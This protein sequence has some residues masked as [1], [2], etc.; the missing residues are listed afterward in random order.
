[1]LAFPARDH[2]T[3]TKCVK[4][5]HLAQWILNTETANLVKMNTE[6]FLYGDEL[7]IAA[8]GQ[9]QPRSRFKVVDESEIVFAFYS[10]RKSGRFSELFENYPFDEDG[11]KPRSSALSE[12]LDSL[13]QSRLVGRMNPDLV[14]Y[15]ID[16]ALKIRFENHVKP[17]LVGKDELLRQFSD[18][19]VRLLKIKG[20]AQ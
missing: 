15:T 12:G 8:F 7:L 14:D 1:M 16:P 10:V 18:E 5:F 11:L 3:Q 20:P 2:A 17:K 9:T 13:Q 19:I 4:F 6:R